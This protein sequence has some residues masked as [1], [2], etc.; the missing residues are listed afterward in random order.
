MWTRY[1]YRRNGEQTQWNIRR[2]PRWH[3]Q[4][5]TTL[6][7]T[8]KLG[9]SIDGK[10]WRLVTFRSKVDDI[11]VNGRKS[12]APRR[13][14]IHYARSKCGIASRGLQSRKQKLGEEKRA[15]DI[16]LMVKR[17]KSVK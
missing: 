8:Y 13:R 4:K 10:F 15:E 9:L 11:P 17:C 3:E 2:W 16:L 12:V 6:L 14:R 1:P 7:N 5:C